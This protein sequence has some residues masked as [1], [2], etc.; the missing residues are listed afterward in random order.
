MFG[1]AIDFFNPLS[2]VQDLIDLVQDVGES[3]D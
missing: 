1:D 3:F 2:D